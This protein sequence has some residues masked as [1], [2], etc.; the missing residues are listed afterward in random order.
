MAA[1]KDV[2][3]G[4]PAL[5][6]VACLAK[7]A[8]TSVAPSYYDGHEHKKRFLEKKR[9]FVGGKLCLVSS[10][11][12]FRYAKPNDP[13]TRKIVRATTEPH[14]HDDATLSILVFDIQIE[15][16]RFSFADQFWVP[17]NMFFRAYPNGVAY[18]PIE[19][20][21]RPRKGAALVW[22]KFRGM[23]GLKLCLP[24]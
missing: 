20:A 11:R 6:R 13:H 12:K 2:F 16:R 7:R 8:G 1:A 4:L 9:V 17:R 22:E 10:L 21:K 18:I 15:G 24:L 19:P 3:A 14:G 23:N 5:Q